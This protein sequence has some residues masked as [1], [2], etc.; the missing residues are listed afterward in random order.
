MT[1]HDV[2]HG[3]LDQWEK[4]QRALR[5]AREQARQKKHEQQFRKASRLLQHATANGL[6]ITFSTT[7]VEGEVHLASVLRKQLAAAQ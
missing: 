5:M 2:G 3:N 6:R 1:S 7:P 4:D